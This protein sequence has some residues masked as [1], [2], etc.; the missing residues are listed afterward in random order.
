MDTRHSRDYKSIQEKLFSHPYKE[1][2]DFFFNRRGIL[3]FTTS[4]I[5]NLFKRSCFHT[6]IRNVSIFSLIDVRFYSS[7]S[8]E[9]KMRPKQFL[10]LLRKL[11]DV[12][13]K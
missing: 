10:H 8:H 4:V 7:P 11:W 3:Q 12:Y 6:L 5:I 2:F 9:F 13:K 1:C